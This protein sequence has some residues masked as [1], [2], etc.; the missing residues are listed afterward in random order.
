MEAEKKENLTCPPGMKIGV[1]TMDAGIYQR[2]DPK[3][4]VIPVEK[5]ERGKSDAVNILKG[6]LY[7]IPAGYEFSKKPGRIFKERK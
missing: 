7:Y 2:N 6:H 3:K 1:A 5:S 4:R